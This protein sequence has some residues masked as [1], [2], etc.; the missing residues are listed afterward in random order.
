MGLGLAE[1][2]GGRDSDRDLWAAIPDRTLETDP[3]EYVSHIVDDSPFGGL[4]W[5]EMNMLIRRAKLTMPQERAFRAYLLGWNLEEIG[6]A[7]STTYQAQG[8]HIF[9]AKRKVLGVPYRGVVTVCI[10]SQGW[11]A[12]REAMR[13]RGK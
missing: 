8:R 13:Q 6:T 1:E 9:I 3:H 11:D 10:E 4:L 12:L 7:F 5:R 2:R